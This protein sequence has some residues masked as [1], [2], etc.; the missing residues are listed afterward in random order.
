MSLLPY[1]NTKVESLDIGAIVLVRLIR[2]AAYLGQEKK[3]M[4]IILY[5]MT[6][7]TI[8]VSKLMILIQ[9]LV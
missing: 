7:Y 6:T 2:I 4:C 9:M 8:R 3:K 1:N 5:S